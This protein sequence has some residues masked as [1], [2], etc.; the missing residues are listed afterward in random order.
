MTALQQ[1]SVH[2]EL[3]RTQTVTCCPKQVSHPTSPVSI[4]TINCEETS[5]IDKIP[6]FFAKS[7]NAVHHYYLYPYIAYRSIVFT[8]TN[9]LFR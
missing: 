5:L 7:F 4:L 1:S 2:V 3:L 6:Q 8:K 9:L